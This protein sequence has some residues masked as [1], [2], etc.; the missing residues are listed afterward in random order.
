[1]SS[2]SHFSDGRT[3][4]VTRV[5]TIHTALC[6]I[7]TLTLSNYWFEVCNIYVP[8]GPVLFVLELVG[9]RQK[10]TNYKITTLAP[11][12]KKP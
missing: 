1:M 12:N 5:K 2:L 3:F 4:C 8:V 10:Q 7:K 11:D 9:Q 6:R